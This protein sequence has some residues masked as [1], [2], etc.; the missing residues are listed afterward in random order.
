MIHIAHILIQSDEMEQCLSALNSRCMRYL[1]SSFYIHQ[2]LLSFLF[3]YLID[4]NNQYNLLDSFCKWDRSGQCQPVWPLILPDILHE[5]YAHISRQ[6]LA[7]H[8][9]ID[10]QSTLGNF[11]VELARHKH[12]FLVNQVRS[13]LHM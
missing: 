11:D 12:V 9:R 6:Y 10:I 7:R 13:I 4:S 2:E 5:W 8:F 3:L 1:Q